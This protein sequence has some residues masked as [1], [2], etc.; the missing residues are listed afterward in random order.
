MIYQPSSSLKTKLLFVMLVA[1]MMWAI[2][3]MPQE[4][5]AQQG[6][7]G[8]QVQHPPPNRTT[9]QNGAMNYTYPWVAPYAEAPKCPQW[10]H[11][12]NKWHGLWNF[13]F[14]C[15]YDHEH[16]HNPSVLNYIFGSSHSSFNEP[17]LTPNEN[18]LKHNAFGWLVL[19]DEASINKGDTYA[20]NGQYEVEC[21]PANSDS[22]K[23]GCVTAARI[24]VHGVGAALGAATRFHSYHAELKICN[25]QNQCGIVR[26][27]GWGDSGALFS[28][29]P[30]G[31]R[32]LLPGES[33]NDELQGNR[34]TGSFAYRAHNPAGPTRPNDIPNF[35]IWEFGDNNGYN[36]IFSYGIQSFDAWGGVHADDLSKTD[37][38][39]PDFQCELNGS[40][41][42]LF[43]IEV[44]I[45]K[46]L[47]NSD[48]VINFQGFTDKQGNIDPSCKTKTAAC[49]PVV[50]QNVPAGI[51]T[52]RYNIRSFISKGV[53]G[54]V[55]EYDSSPEGVYWIEY[56]N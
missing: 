50:F 40:T 13:K 27:G 34:P 37:L 22:D 38:R 21:K 29:Y 5:Q 53:I 24:R 33:Y 31:P 41:M 1:V 36:Q 48:R 39:C 18:S 54:V 35:F 51:E 17:W 4:A 8:Y 30:T 42:K 46:Q 25:R 28:P 49:I 19:Q 44:Q 43:T 2:V 15:H 6:Y 45:P 52:A 9:Y 56:P 7:Q 47:Q 14:G 26:T 11:D 3:I 12:N 16:K 32:I 23:V 20:A 10:A 55:P